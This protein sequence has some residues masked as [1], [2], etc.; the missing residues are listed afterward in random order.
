MTGTPPGV[1]PY[2]EA[3]DGPKRVLTLHL[4]MPTFTSKIP[5]VVGI[6][7]RQYVV[8][9]GSIS[10]EIPADRATHVSVC[11]HGEYMQ[12]AA[13]ALLAPER[14]AVL[15]YQTHFVGGQ[16]TLS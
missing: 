10:F 13:S 16:A 4:T 7:G 8:V 1:V 3:H 9:W 14:P 15:T 6:D 2:V 5:P 11:V 12:Q